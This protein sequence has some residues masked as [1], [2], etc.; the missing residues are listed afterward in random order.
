MFEV[1]YQRLDWLSSEMLIF[2]FLGITMGIYG[3]LFCKLN[4]LWSRTFR[5]LH[6]VKKWP[7]MEVLVVVLVTSTVGWYN[8]YTRISGTRLVEDLL[9]ECREKEKFDGV[10]P[11][12]VAGIPRLVKLIVV[13]MVVKGLLYVSGCEGVTDGGRTIVTFGMK[14]PA[15]IFIPTMVCFWGGEGG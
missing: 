9:S 1:S 7:W 6:W 2:I 10:C 13:A 12:G 4:I 5:Q 3:A 8:P 11:D 14:I 15:G